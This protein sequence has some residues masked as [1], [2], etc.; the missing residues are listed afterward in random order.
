[1]AVQLPTG[2][3]EVLSRADR[4]A[5]PLVRAG[6]WLMLACCLARLWLAPL[7]SSFWIDEIG[8][9][10]VLHHGGNHPSFA[11]APQVPASLYYWL[12]RAAERLFGFSEISYRIPSLL[13]MGVA[14]FFIARIAARLIHPQAGWL[15]AFACLALRGFNY[16][17]ADA[18]PYALGTCVAAAGLWVLIRWLDTGRLGYAAAFAAA[19]ALLWRVHLLFWPFYLVYAFYTALRIYRRETT[20]TWLRAGL[21]FTITG[22]ALVP[23]LGEALALNRHAKAHVIAALPTPRD[24]LHTLKAGMVAGFAVV[25]AVFS[26]VLHWPWPSD[27]PRSSIALVVSWWLFHPLGL[28]ALSWLTGNSVFV[29]RYLALGLPGVALTATL[30]AAYFLPSSW[31]R[32]LTLAFAVGVLLV[33][34]QWNTKSPPHHNS[35]WRGA[36]NAINHLGFSVNTPV[37]CPSPFIEAQPPVWTPDYPLPG[38]LYSHLDVYPLQAKPILFPFGIVPSPESLDYARTLAQTLLP[39]AGRFAILGGDRSVWCWRDYFA[40]RPELAGWQYRSLRGFGDIEIV[41]F[42]RQGAR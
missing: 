32:P 29:P 22:L 10:F 6:L 7:P 28:F 15:A 38:F 33:M 5:S 4:G 18:R 27:P 11:V 9:A 24:L 31:W 16:Q 20:V 8:T 26:R 14:L 30:A 19:G 1:M 12:P 2:P 3:A 25:A 13:V 42:E 39:N 34:G 41:V 36:A 35:D 40:R 21:L 37:I 17:A 23:V